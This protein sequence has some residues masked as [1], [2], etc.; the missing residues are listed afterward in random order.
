MVKPSNNIPS[1][2]NLGPNM[3]NLNVGIGN[4]TLA[5]EEKRKRQEEVSLA[6]KKGFANAIFKG[7][8]HRTQLKQHKTQLGINLPS[9]RIKKMKNIKI[10]INSDTLTNIT[11]ATIDV[12]SIPVESASQSI[13]FKIT[14]NDTKYVYILKVFIVQVGRN[15][16]PFDTETENYK[17]MKKILSAR[18]TPHIFTYIDSKSFP[19][20]QSNSN[21]K[22]TIILN[23]KLHSKITDKLTNYKNNP[24]IIAYY[25]ALLIETSDYKLETLENFLEGTLSKSKIENISDIIFNILFQI[26]YT[27]YIFNK[28]KI[29]HNDLHDGNIFISI[30]ENNI[31]DTVNFNIEYNNVYNFDKKKFY[32]PNIGLSVRIFDFDRA[33]KAEDDNYGRRTC[34]SEVHEDYKN[35]PISICNIHEYRDSYK[36][37]STIYDIINNN[38]SHNNDYLVVLDWIKSLFKNESIIDNPKKHHAKKLD[39]NYKLLFDG[40]SAT[41]ESIKEIVILLATKIESKKNIKISG[42]YNEQEIGYYN[43]IRPISGEYYEDGIKSFI[44]NTKKLIQVTHG[45][46]CTYGEKGSIRMTKIGKRKVPVICK[47]SKS[48]RGKKLIT[49]LTKNGKKKYF[50]KTNKCKNKLCWHRLS[51]KNKLLKKKTLKFFKKKKKKKNKN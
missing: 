23:S 32:L 49:T 7:Y 27:L 20:E 34:N 19:V 15:N 38:K 9:N 8:I 26:M 42:Q 50:Y 43:I 39:S 29:T 6:K 45:G 4:N 17:T 25:N 18:L 28:L 24:D 5:E 3:A 35:L 41:M 13:V 31:L 44:K 48:F 22:K 37:L 11:D 40:E 1:P 51:A 14:D 30:A 16:I 10:D 21:E 46:T 47:K 2:D 33:S 36:V 12:I